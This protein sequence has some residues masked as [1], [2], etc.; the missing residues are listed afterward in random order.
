M[1]QEWPSFEI[2][3]KDHLRTNWCSVRQASAYG[4]GVLAEQ[5][6]FNLRNEEAALNWM[7]CL[8]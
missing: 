8:S 3:L 7:E 5:T 2:I 1:S 4:L 6:P